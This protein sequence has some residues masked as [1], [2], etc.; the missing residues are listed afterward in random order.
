[1]TE[2]AFYGSFNAR[3]LTYEE[4]GERFVAPAQYNELAQLEHCLLAG[5]RGSGKTTLLKM[6]TQPA[7]MAWGRVSTTQIEALP[8]TGVYVPA[9]LLW[10]NQ[11]DVIREIIPADSPIAEHLSR[12]A[13]TA[14]AAYGFFESCETLPPLSSRKEELFAREAAK[15][16]AIPEAYPSFGG[17]KIGLRSRLTEIRQLT[18]QIATALGGFGESPPI[19]NYVYRDL[20]D[21]VSSLADV[22]QHLLSLPKYHRWALCFDELEISPQWLREYLI[23]SLRSADQRLVFKLSTSPLA[24]DAVGALNFEGPQE[25][26]DYRVVRL[27]YTG[28][29]QGRRF[30]ERLAR[31][32]LS[33]ERGEDVDPKQV[34][35][36]SPFASDAKD[37]GTYDPNSEFWTDLRKA[38]H[39]DSTLRSLLRQHKIDLNDVKKANQKERDQFLRKIKP[40]VMLRLEF[41]KTR[42]K[43]SGG[44][45]PRKISKLYSG[46]EALYALSEGNPRWLNGMLTDMLRAAA[47]SK[48]ISR[49]IQARI[50]WQTSGRYQTLLGMLPKSTVWMGDRSVSLMQLVTS[51]GRYLARRT[52]DEDFP[53][54]P[55][56]SIQ[57]DGVTPVQYLKLLE[58]GAS[59]G[60]FV[61][62]DAEAV[63]VPKSARGLRLRLSFLL[64][65][66]YRLPLRLYDPISLRTTLRPVL[67]K[68]I[69]ANV[70]PKPSR[71]IQPVQEN[72]FELS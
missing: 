18:H 71:D 34:L 51:I 40:I 27:W 14:N 50:V 54:D 69:P 19:P 30:C 38:A 65:P 24:P 49:E 7:Q 33:R 55:I 31:A 57:V 45:R 26:Q 9:D 22:S 15:Q 20:L 32:V 1:M 67:Q 63:A 52:I 29:I 58:L 41:R 36:R 60:A 48:R 66:R 8:F 13:V 47:G 46:A 6:L 23:K 5:P 3:Q 21:T 68:Y 70:S 53:L 17:L 44:R 42:G 28:T 12:A 39:S 61:H 11:L 10:A 4:V 72:L 2:P 43:L 56:G 25:G 16:L 35:G 59:H 37:R 62:V 64:A